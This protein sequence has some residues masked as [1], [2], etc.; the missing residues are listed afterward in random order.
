MAVIEKSSLKTQVNFLTIS[1]RLLRE[2]NNL[3]LIGDYPKELIDTTLELL[4]ICETELNANIILY[5]T[6]VSANAIANSQQS[7]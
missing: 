2:F 7:D 3:R 4:L 1:Q 6:K 5:T